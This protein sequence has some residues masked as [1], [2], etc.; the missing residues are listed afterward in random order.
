MFHYCGGKGACRRKVLRFSELENG[1]RMF[2]FN[3]RS[4]DVKELDKI[5]NK[6][7]KFVLCTFPD[8]GKLT[9]KAQLILKMFLYNFGTGL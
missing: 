7:L 3:C 6:C 8:T 9:T 5:K 4:K 1:F 2:N